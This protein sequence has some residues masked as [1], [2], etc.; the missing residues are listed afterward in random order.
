MAPVYLAGYDTEQPMCVEAVRSL[1]GIHRRQKIPATFFLVGILVEHNREELKDLLDDDL[2]EV[3]SHTYMHR[4]IESMPLGEV[5]DQLRR[6]QDLLGEVFGCAPVGFRTPGGTTAGYRGDRE[7]LS[8]FA[9]MGFAYVSSQGWGPGQTMPAPVIPP[10][11][12]REEGFPGLLEIPMHGWHE[13]LFTR[14][15]PWQSPSQPLNSEAPRNI[16]GWMAPFLSDVET[17]VSGSMPYYGPTMHP[18]S[19]RRFDP[20]CEQ[21]SAFLAEIK[22]RGMEFMKFNDFARGWKADGNGSKS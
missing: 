13:N 15:H 5:R 16:E 10:F 1:V 3:A 18:W 19:L 9:E 17:A 20:E 6:T 12:Y 4:H 11:D 21:V 2:F 22:K 7:R 8:V 14:V